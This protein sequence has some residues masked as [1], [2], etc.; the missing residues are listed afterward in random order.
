MIQTVE[1]MVD[2]HGSVKLLKTISVPSARRAIVIILDEPPAQ[3]SKPTSI[4]GS[5]RTD[6]HYSHDNNTFSTARNPLAG[7]EQSSGNITNMMYDTVSS[8][9]K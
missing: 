3:R 8:P 6:Y 4:F 5:L 2:E 9:I 1:A 7:V